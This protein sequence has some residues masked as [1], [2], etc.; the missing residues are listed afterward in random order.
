MFLSCDQVYEPTFFERIVDLFNKEDVD[1]AVAEEMSYKPTT[2]I[3]KLSE[4]DRKIIQKEYELDPKKGVILPGIYKK[5]ILKRIFKKFKRP[6]LENVTI[7]DHAIIYYEAYKLSNKIG[8]I[9][10]AVY[11]SE[12]KTILSLINHYYY[13]G[14][15]ARAVK[16]ILPKEY[17]MMFK[18]KMNHRIK[19][20]NWLSIDSLLTLP[21]IFVKGLGFN[22]GSQFG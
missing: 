9:M 17:E 5:T 3:E 10:N 21:V 4:I 6:L 19:N 12:P 2:I 15:R 16:N 13:W 14:K 11:H 1:M 22:L 8:L 20:I 7:H 18:S